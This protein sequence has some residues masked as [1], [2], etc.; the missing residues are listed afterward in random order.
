MPQ[1]KNTGGVVERIAL[2]P[3]KG[4]PRLEVTQARCVAGK[5]MEGDW[6]FGNKDSV[7]LLAAE[8]IARIAAMPVPGLCTA[9]F[10]ANIVT[11]GVALHAWAP[12]QRF[13][14]GEALL[15]VERVGKRCF[16]ECAHYQQHGPCALAGECL[17]ATVAQ[18][19]VTKLGDSIAAE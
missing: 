10:E 3:E 5:G 17:F 18:S 8:T 7:T 1:Q 11:R 14:A 13:W 16:D 2:Q 15:A 6:H 19:G 12:G 4:A 9:R